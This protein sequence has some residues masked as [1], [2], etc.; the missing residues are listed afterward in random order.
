MNLSLIS[1]F[2]SQEDCATRRP[3][4]GRPVPGPRQLELLASEDQTSEVRTR[5][6][7]KIS[8]VSH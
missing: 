1:P 4:R 2:V 7:A 3:G 8:D 6:A 5:R